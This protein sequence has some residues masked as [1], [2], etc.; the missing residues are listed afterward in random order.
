M[1][2]ELGLVKLQVRLEEMAADETG[3]AREVRRLLKG[4]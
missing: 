4:L 3:H 2:K 1:A